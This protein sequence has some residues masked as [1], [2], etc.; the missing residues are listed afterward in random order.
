V[1][2]RGVN[3]SIAQVREAHLALKGFPIPAWS[4]YGQV[5]EE[6]MEAYGKDAVRRAGK[7]PLPQVNKQMYPD[8]RG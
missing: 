5:G 1:N 8:R 6:L 4:D 3:F 7:V 2:I